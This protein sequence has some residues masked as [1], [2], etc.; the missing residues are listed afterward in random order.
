LIICIL[1]SGVKQGFFSRIDHHQHNNLVKE[2]AGSSDNVHMPH[3]DRSKLPGHTA[4][5]T[6]TPFP[7]VHG[8]GGHAVTVLTFFDRTAHGVGIG[9]PTSVSHTITPRSR[10]RAAAAAPP[11]CQSLPIWRVDKHNIKK[12]QLQPLGKSA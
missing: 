5:R 3:G 6:V 11:G 2:L 1:S 10:T 4:I 9:A 12:I 7:T 8:H